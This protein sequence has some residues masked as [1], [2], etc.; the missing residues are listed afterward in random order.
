MAP[1]TVTAL[2]KPTA[3]QLAG[4]AEVF[5]RYRR[6]YGHPVVAGQKLKSAWSEWQGRAVAPAAVAAWRTASTSANA[7]PVGVT[8]PH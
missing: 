4:V 3:E 1:V 2:T 8:C 6:H 7:A 5:D